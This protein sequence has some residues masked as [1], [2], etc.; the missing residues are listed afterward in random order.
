MT[1]E[2]TPRRGVVLAT[3]VAFLLGLLVHALAVGAHTSNVT[4]NS[5][6]Q[7]ATRASDPATAQSSGGSGPT[8][9]ESGA[10]AG[11]SHSQPGAVAA[12]VAF[13]CTGQSLLSMDPLSAEDAVR[14]MA[15]SA[16]ADHQAQQATSAL[17][18]VRARLASGTGPII[19]RQA[20]V[21]TRVDLFS[22]DRAR[23]EVWSVGVLSRQGIAPPQAAWAISTFDLVWERDDWRV[24]SE[25]VVP[26]PA[27]IIDN[28]T[29]PATAV[30]LEAALSGF[31]DT[32]SRP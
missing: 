10:P 12:S 27:P 25:M 4:R 16:T 20:A 9:L 6:G 3:A 11:F 26:G 28:S 21:S 17:R 23:V 18:E 31:T 7:E 2:R 8:R 30:Q 19:Y 15:S 22:P 1:R 5:P 29:P 13:V 14:Q 24:V 32:G